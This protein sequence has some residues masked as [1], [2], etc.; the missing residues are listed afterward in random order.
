MTVGLVLIMQFL[1]PSFFTEVFANFIVSI[2]VDLFLRT[3]QPFRRGPALESGIDVDGQPEVQTQPEA[4]THAPC[5]DWCQTLHLL[6]IQENMLC[7]APYEEHRP[8]HFI[9]VDYIS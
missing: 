4:R 2:L 8:H 9:F 3:Q 1:L 5:I 7:E 6:M